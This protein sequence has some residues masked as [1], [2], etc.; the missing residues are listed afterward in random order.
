MGIFSLIRINRAPMIY[1]H[2]LRQN[3]RK[4]V[5]GDNDF[6]VVEDIKKKQ[7]HILAAINQKFVSNK[8]FM[9]VISKITL[10]KRIRFSTNDLP[11]ATEITQMQQKAIF[12]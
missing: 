12:E 10:A 2:I 3:K 1:D 7:K 8:K 11:L 4:T 9:A 5:S 6:F